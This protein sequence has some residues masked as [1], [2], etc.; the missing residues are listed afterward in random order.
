MHTFENTTLGQPVD[1]VKGEGVETHTLLARIEHYPTAIEAADGG[2]FVVPMGACCLT[3]GIDVQ[4]DRLEMLVIGWGVGEESWLIDRHV[5]PG[6]TEKPE[7][8]EELDRLRD[9]PYRHESGVQLMIQAACIDSAGHRTHI[10]YDYASKHAARRVYAIIGRDGQRPIVS[11]PSPRRWGRKQRKVPLYTVGTD[12]AKAVIVGRLKLTRPSPDARG[13]PGYVHIPVADW[14][15]EELVEQ[16]TSEK[17]VKRFHKGVPYTTWVKTRPRNEM[18]DCAVYGLAALRLLN[19]KLAAI[20]ADLLRQAETLETSRRD[21]PETN[22]A[23]QS[24]PM[25]DPVPQT[26]PRPKAHGRRRVVSGYLRR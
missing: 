3:A 13:I 26:P 25:Q 22:T 2:G 20:A 8:W 4:D 5:I 16:L 19:P 18:L 6:N 14:A 21:A 15:D 7:P 1:P 11:S 24:S 12:A 17:L 9:T 10:V 23:A